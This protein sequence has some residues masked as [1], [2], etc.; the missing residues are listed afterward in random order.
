VAIAAIAGAAGIGKSALAV[1]AAHQH[2]ARF[3]DGQLYV[4]L[5]AATAGVQPVAPSLL[6]EIPLP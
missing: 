1:H 4:D 5:Q 3:P 6:I 2:A